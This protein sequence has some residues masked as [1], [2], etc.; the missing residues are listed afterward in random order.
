MCATTLGFKYGFGLNLL[1]V[2]L[3]VGLHTCL[4]VSMRNGVYV[5]VRGQL[6]GVSSPLLPCSPQGSNAGR[7]V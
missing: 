7:Q 2:L 4:R 6:L 1:R 5:E 3:C